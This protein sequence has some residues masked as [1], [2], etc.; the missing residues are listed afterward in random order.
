VKPYE[1]RRADRDYQVG[2]VLHLRE[3][4]PESRTYSGFA[5]WVVVTYITQPGERGLPADLCVWASAA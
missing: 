3:W 5:V 2:D 1:V 4:L